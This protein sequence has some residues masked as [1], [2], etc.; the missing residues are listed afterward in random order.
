M[1][2]EAA[3]K[4]KRKQTSWPKKLCE[5]C[6]VRHKHFGL[7]GSV[8]RLAVGRRR[9]ESLSANLHRHVLNDMC[10]NSAAVIGRV[11]MEVGTQWLHGPWLGPAL[12]HGLRQGAPG[13]GE[14]ASRSAANSMGSEGSCGT[15][16]HPVEGPNWTLSG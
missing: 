12:V 9:V 3:P 2:A 14:R 7:P 6:G 1:A 15:P 8:A 11:P 16:W 4:R 13:R 10:G 5:D